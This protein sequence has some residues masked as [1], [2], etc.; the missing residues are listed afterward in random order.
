MARADPSTARAAPSPGRKKAR[1]D[2]R[3]RGP[4]R[5]ENGD[6]GGSLPFAHPSTRKVWG[7][8]LLGTDEPESRLFGLHPRD[9]EQSCQFLQLQGSFQVF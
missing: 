9:R 1:P 6:V 5:I 8:V 4:K 3:G 7:F 2:R